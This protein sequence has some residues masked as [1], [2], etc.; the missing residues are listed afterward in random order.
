MPRVDAEVRGI[1][2]GNF[3]RELPF[4]VRLKPSPR[5]RKLFRDPPERR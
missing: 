4:L 1:W 3:W 2:E 5:R